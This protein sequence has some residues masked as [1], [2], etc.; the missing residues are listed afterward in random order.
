MIFLQL[1]LYIIIEKFQKEDPRIKII[2]NQKNMGTLYSRSIGVLAA[3]GKYLFNLDN[4]DMFLDKDVFSIILNYAKK[5]GFDIIGFKA[6]Y[7][8]YGP[9]ILTNKIR[10]N[11]FPE[12]T[13][14]RVLLQP[15]LGYYPIR[16]DESLK[17]HY[18]IDCLL[19][20]KCIKTK[21]Y[22]KA[23]NK[24]GEE[25]YSRYMVVGEDGVATYF[26]YNTA[27]S[28]K[29]IGK[30]GTLHIKTR[31]SGSKRKIP[32]TQSNSY[33][34]YIIDTVI[35]FGKDT[36]NNRKILVALMNDLFHKKQL[37]ETIQMNEY[38]K[39][40]FISCVNK[41]LNMKFIPNDDKEKI[42]KKADKLN[43]LKN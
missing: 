22:Q 32:V 36:F 37:K 38:N 5:T 10:E 33:L 31:G 14:D 29:Y 12:Q 11:L 26:L 1:K 9:N 43:L 8:C 34:L 2:N 40:L 24:L 21:I 17:S 39:N 4:D 25:R 16:P 23:L 42:R 7:S 27:E 41:I 18:T 28:M 30:Y 19:W 35:E 3:K 20:T 6:V 15:E 13:R